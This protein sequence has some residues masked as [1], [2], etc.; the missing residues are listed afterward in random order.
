MVVLPTLAIV[1]ISVSIAIGDV[2]E[3]QSSRLDEGEILKTRETTV[4]ASNLIIFMKKYQV[5]DFPS[6]F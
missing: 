1:S 4:I 2:T 5:K 6:G 3:T